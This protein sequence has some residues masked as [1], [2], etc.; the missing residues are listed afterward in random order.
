MKKQVSLRFNVH[1]Y[2]AAW[3][4]CNHHGMSMEEAFET[5]CRFLAWLLDHPVSGVIMR[6]PF[7]QH[8][9][10]FVLLKDD[11]DAYVPPVNV[12]QVPAWNDEEQIDV[13]WQIPVLLWKRLDLMADKR[14]VD[15]NTLFYI[16]V[17]LIGVMER[18]STAPGK[19]QA[20]LVLNATHLLTVV[21]LAR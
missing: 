1:W 8:T 21:H 7:G 18:A 3:D 6:F 16:A 4:I 12:R 5:A 9:L 17:N 10:A 13:E 14:D 19:A 2:D 11:A 15:L 20:Y